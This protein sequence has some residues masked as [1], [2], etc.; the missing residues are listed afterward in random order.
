MFLP[1]AR[2]ENI[3]VQSAGDEVLIYDL[4]TNKAF[5]LNETATR[6]FSACDGRTSFSD[7]KRRYEHFTDD[8]I[9]AALNELSRE[10]L[11][12]TEFDT[13][14][15]RRGLL[16]KAALAAIALPI[17]TA[18]AVPASA[19][20]LSCGQLN[21]GCSGG[22]C[23]PSLVCGGRV[24]GGSTSCCWPNGA[25]CTTSDFTNCCGQGCFLNGNPVGTCFGGVV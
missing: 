24:G 18:V 21:A 15:S 2:T 5:C 8:V 7:L 16:H 25:P 9:N 3:V 17:V 13:R 19:Q 12:T 1:K 20:A 23:C 6:V 4:M 22:G 11:L 10:N 14:T